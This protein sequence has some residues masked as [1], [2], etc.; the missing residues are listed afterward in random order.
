MASAPVLAPVLAPAPPLYNI[1]E[2][3][4]L[5]FSKLKKYEVELKRHNYII[6]LNLINAWLSA[7]KIT[8]KSLSEFKNI[9]KATIFSDSNIEFFNQNHEQINPAF[10]CNEVTPNSIFDIINTKLKTIGYTFCTKTKDKK[11][12]VSILAI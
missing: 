12:F 6:L 4:H 2:D 8:I 11:Q 9:D 7:Y 5:Y 3:P 1:K 10:K